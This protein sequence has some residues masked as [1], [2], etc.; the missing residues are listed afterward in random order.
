MLLHAP[1][2]KC[3]IDTIQL[4]SGTRPNIAQFMLSQRMSQTGVEVKASRIVDEVVI[5]DADRTGFADAKH[6]TELN[7]GYA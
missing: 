2:I 1:H 6:Q 5:P 7:K 4:T 3:A